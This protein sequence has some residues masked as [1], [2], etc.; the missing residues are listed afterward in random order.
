[1]QNP[2]IFNERRKKIKRKN[3]VEKCRQ[4]GL[5]TRSKGR[6]KTRFF[7][8]IPSDRSS[9][10]LLLSKMPF[11]TKIRFLADSSENRKKIER[12]EE[13]Y[14]TSGDTVEF[15]RNF[16]DYLNEK[17]PYTVVIVILLLLCFVAMVFLL[18]GMCYHF[19]LKTNFMVSK[20]PLWHQILI[21]VYK[22]ILLPFRCPKYT[23]LPRSTYDTHLV[24]GIRHPIH[25]LRLFP[26]LCSFP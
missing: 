13:V 20:D 25:S 15:A 8:F 1:M 2:D 21:L 22:F 18:V 16:G 19:W 24:N 6:G 14:S 11:H 9:T 12:L 26:N 10:I 4:I 5:C 7:Y 23:I 3:N 17:I